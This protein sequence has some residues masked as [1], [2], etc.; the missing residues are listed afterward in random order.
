MLQPKSVRLQERKSTYCSAIWT[1]MKAASRH[2]RK[3]RVSATLRDGSLWIPQGRMCPKEIYSVLMQEFAGFCKTSVDVRY[4]LILSVSTGSNA[5]RCG[6]NRSSSQSVYNKRKIWR[7]SLSEVLR[8]T[9][10]CRSGHVCRFSGTG[11][12]LYNWNSILVQEADTTARCRG[13]A[14][15]CSCHDRIVPEKKRCYNNINLAVRRRFY[16]TAIN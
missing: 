15:I 4:W 16:V 11:T 12:F 10:E 5:G 13:L 14:G 6:R 8:N 3:Y 7:S 9:G 1:L 2:K